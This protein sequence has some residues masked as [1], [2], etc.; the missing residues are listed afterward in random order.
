[1]RERDIAPEVLE[2]RLQAIYPDASVRV[3]DPIAHFGT[4]P[5]WYIFREGAR[6]AG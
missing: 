4:Q 1:L 3:Q 5:V 2:A 6:I